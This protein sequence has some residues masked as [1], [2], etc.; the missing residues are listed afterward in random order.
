MVNPASLFDGSRG[1][2]ASSFPAI[3]VVGFGD[4]FGFLMCFS[5]I[6]LLPISS[7]FKRM[8]LVTLQIHYTLGIQPMQL[9]GYPMMPEA[10]SQKLTGKS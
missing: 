3:S 10:Y 9:S 2:D 7:Y 8:V 5:A 1:A 6:L 4:R